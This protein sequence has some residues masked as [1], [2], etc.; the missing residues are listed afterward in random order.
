M[1]FGTILDAW[2]NVI[3]ACDRGFSLTPFI[4]FGRY[5][6]YQEERTSVS[7]WVSMHVDERQVV[8]GMDRC[9]DCVPSHDV[10][11]ILWMHDKTGFL[12]ETTHRRIRIGTC[13]L[14]SHPFY[15][16]QLCLK[17]PTKR[18][19]L[20][21]SMFSCNKAKPIRETIPTSLKKKTRRK[22]SHPVHVSVSK[23]RFDRENA[24]GW[25]PDLVLVSIGKWYRD[26]FVG[27]QDGL[28]GEPDR[29]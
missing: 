16:S 27:K 17:K 20:S 12:E 7:R 2:K 13:K 10:V 23:S 21:S 19:D 8:S 22:D 1:I 18:K 24:S 9:H 15:H 4:S 29:R 25:V 28:I 26:T 3:D 14:S 5:R 6:A 11:R